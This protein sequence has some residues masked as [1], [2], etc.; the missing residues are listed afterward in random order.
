M[1]KRKYKNLSKN[2]F[3]FPLV[4]VAL[5][6]ILTL[7]FSY[8]FFQYTKTGA[9]N[10]FG[11]AYLNFTFTDTS[12]INIGNDEPISYD[13]LDS[14]HQITFTINANSE[15]TDGIRYKVY[16]IPGETINNKNLLLNE[17]MS[18]QFIPAEDADGFTTNINNYEVSKSPSFIDNKALIS[19]GVVTNADTTIPAKTY[20]LN[21]WIDSSKI[22]VSSTTKRLL[23]EEGYPSL[24]D[25]SDGKLENVNRYIKNDNTL[26][27]TTLFPAESSDEGKIIYTTNEFKNSYYS[28]K[29]VVEAEEVEEDK[30]LVYF[31]P[32]GGS[33]NTETMMV[34]VGSN[35][36]NL[37]APTRAGYTFLG[38][39]INSND[40]NYITNNVN[41][42]LSNDHVLKAIWQ[43]NS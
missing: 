42:I 29:I 21:L 19:T 24:A 28:M 6:I 32:E 10:S 4:S 20:T 39:K 26:V 9:T 23:N 13:E 5:V 7:A 43:K 41:V 27:S 25:T 16:A 35:Y 12:G 17:V 38:W 34:T 15:L 1:S 30:V 22:T 37:P 3:F 2:H 14:N 31:N 33:M 18:M 36:P 8:A 11:T 40:V